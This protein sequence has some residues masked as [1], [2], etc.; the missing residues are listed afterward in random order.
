M[1]I[2]SWE[3]QIIPVLSRVID[4]KFTDRLNL[5]GKSGWE[6]VGI[7]TLGNTDE[8]FIIFKRPLDLVQQ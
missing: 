6:L 8:P 5:K 7:F 4:Q 2:I 1:K 3:Y